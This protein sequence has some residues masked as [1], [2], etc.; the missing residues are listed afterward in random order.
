MLKKARFFTFSLGPYELHKRSAGPYLLR[1][2]IARE[3]N[4]RLLFNINERDKYNLV[5]RD[6]LGIDILSGTKRSSFIPFLSTEYE[7]LVD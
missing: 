6:G 4:M 5:G 2:Q 1:M 7:V 3:E